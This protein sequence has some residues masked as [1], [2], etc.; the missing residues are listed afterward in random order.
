MAKRWIA[1]FLMAVL[2]VLFPVPAF[3]SI[4]LAEGE[5]VLW[6]DRLAVD[7][8]MP[9]AVLGLYDWLVAEGEKGVDGAL[10]DPTKAEFFP[11]YGFYGY[12][13]SILKNMEPVRFTPAS[14]EEENQKAARTAIQLYKEESGLQARIE[15]VVEYALAVTHAFNRDHPEVFWLRGGFAVML[16]ISYTYDSDGTANFVQR[17]MLCFQKEKEGM[18]I[19][20]ERYR[21]PATLAEDIEKLNEAADAILAD[22]PEGSRREQLAYLNRWL[23]THN[24]YRS[25][26]P[27][28]SSRH[29]L[30]ALMGNAAEDG[31]VCEGYARALKI[32]CDRAS[33]PCVLVNGDAYYEKGGT[34]I[35]HMW[36][37]VQMEDGHWYAIDVT[38]NDPVIRDEEG[39]P[40]P[41]TESGYEDEEYF[42]VGAGSESDG[43]PFAESHVIVND[44]SEAGLHFVKKVWLH[45]HHQRKINQFLKIHKQ[46][47]SKSSCLLRCS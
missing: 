46:A 25:G 3:A 14:G 30:T 13:L 7:P 19:R 16:P 39:K 9:Q 47:V 2:C 32:L 12:E 40:I 11:D 27:D 44:V 37:S 4:S 45:T 1:L 35:P 41:G 18:D 21:N 24:S 20:Q 42:L 36:N 22:L 23:T 38:W 43:L 34:P 29:P 31:P 5:H 33:I 6:I 10:A 26:T 8:E 17:I 15:A 28:E